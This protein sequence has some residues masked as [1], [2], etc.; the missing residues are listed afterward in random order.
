MKIYR[1]AISSPPHMPIFKE[2]EDESHTAVLAV[3]IPN[4]H[5]N[6]AII[7]LETAIQAPG[8]SS[9]EQWTLRTKQA[10]LTLYPPGHPMNR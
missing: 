7:W 8:F 5:L 1:R 9:T 10:R 3:Q 6:S 2:G 4:D